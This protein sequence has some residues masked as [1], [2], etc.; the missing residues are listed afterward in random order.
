MSRPFFATAAIAFVVTLALGLH[1][2]AQTSRRAD[3]PR[4]SDG[5]PDFSGIWQ[6][7]SAAD[8]D[9]EPHNARVDAPPGV[10]IVDGGTIPYQPW[11]REQQARNFTA[12]ATADC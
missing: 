6:T 1:G 2:V 9:L 11:A 7:L 8:D 12:R 4:T 5:K 10:G 3:I